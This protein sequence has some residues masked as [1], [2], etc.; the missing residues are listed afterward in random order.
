M[1]KLSLLALR[2]HATKIAHQQRNFVVGIKA[3]VTAAIADGRRPT[4][5]TDDE[6]SV[7]D[8]SMEL[9]KKTNAPPTA[10]MNAQKSAM[11]KRD[12]GSDRH[13]CLL[14]LVGHADECGTVSDTQGL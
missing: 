4:G 3:E 5:M 1:A 14:H 11:V 2:R 8:F 10:A 12:C 6:E 13:Q 9:H 7:Y